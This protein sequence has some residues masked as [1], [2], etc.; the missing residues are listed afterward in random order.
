ML[1][2]PSETCLESGNTE[3]ALPSFVHDLLYGEHIGFRAFWE[4]RELHRDILSGADPRVQ[5][6]G[7]R[8]IAMPCGAEQAR[9]VVTA[10]TASRRCVELVAACNGVSAVWSNPT[11]AE[12][13]GG[14]A[15]QSARD[16]CRAARPPRLSSALHGAAGS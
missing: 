5:V 10:R 12:W 14:P 9:P 6:R 3:P 7:W 4:A 16:P 15:A 8:C 1:C 2:A 13:S 11:Q